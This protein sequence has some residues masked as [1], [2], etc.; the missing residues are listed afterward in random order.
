MKGKEFLIT[1]EF[2]NQLQSEIKSEQLSKF[3][4][5]NEV[6]G[7]L[8]KRS[9]QMLKSRL[10]ARVPEGGFK[11]IRSPHSL[12]FTMVQLENA[13]YSAIFNVSWAVDTIAVLSRRILGYA[14]DVRTLLDSEDDQVVNT[15]LP[16]KLDI[17]QRYAQEAASRA[18]QVIY[19]LD[20]FNNLVIE[21][22]DATF[23]QSEDLDEF[24]VGLFYVRDDIEKMRDAWTKL[25]NFLQTI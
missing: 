24:K 17:I 10:D 8:M 12:C 2:K 21:V 18:K 3:S 15:Y 16:V 1:E 11:Y 13:R 4:K 9:N 7:A 23:E 5:I 6:S 14:N 25:A 22:R 20:N 19:E